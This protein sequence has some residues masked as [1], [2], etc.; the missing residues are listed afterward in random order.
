MNALTAS[1]GSRLS[2]WYFFSKINCSWVETRLDAVIKVFIKK[3]S[4][5]CLVPVFPIPFYLPCNAA[6]FS[7][8]DLFTVMLSSGFT[9]SVLAVH[10]SGCIFS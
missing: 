4:W 8:M 3:N 5:K 7:M 10:F 9:S 2:L 6:C 1:Y